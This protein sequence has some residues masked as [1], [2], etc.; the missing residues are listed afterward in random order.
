VVGGGAVTMAQLRI[1]APR[2]RRAIVTAPPPTTN[3]DL[4]VGH[5]SG[6][7]L[8]ADFHA[9]Y[10]R[11]RGIAARYQTGLDNH[12]SYVGLKAWQKGMAAADLMRAYNDAIVSTLSAANVDAAAIQATMDGAEHAALTQRLFSVLHEQG[13]IIARDVPSAHCDRCGMYLFEA[14]VRGKCA[15]CRADSCGGSCEVCG[16]PNDG[17]DLLE[18]RCNRC[19]G[20]AV[21]RDVRRLFLVLEHYRDELRRVVDDTVMPPSVRA[22]G[23]RMLAQPLPEI[24]VSHLT[25]C[26]VPV[27]I[28]GFE[29]QRI[30]AW[31]ELPVVYLETAAVE[32]GPSWETMWSSPDVDNVQFFGF[33]NSYFHLFFCPVVYRAAG[34]HIR[35]PR[36]F[37]VNEFLLLDGS[38]FSTSRNHAIW[39]RELIGPY[40][41]DLVRFYTAW[42]R[43]EAEQTNFTMTGFVETCR[44][45]LIDGVQRWLRELQARVAGEFGG[46]VPATG[47]WTAAHRAFYYDIRRLTAEAAS[48]WSAEHFSP[49]R[50]ARVAAELARLAGRFGRSEEAARGVER[51]WNERRTAVALECAAAKQLGLILHP[52]M[53]EFSASLLAALAL[54]PPFRWEDSPRWVAAGT[55]LPA[56]PWTFFRL[57]SLDGAVHPPQPLAVHG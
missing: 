6:P 8:A 17:G 41:A 46:A 25:D 31:F 4:H 24:A 32:G 54:S 26:G 9:R 15:H 11:M 47:L 7:Y 42:V 38:K 5:L 56:E 48:A 19:G 14:Y 44:R 37:V 10:L 50:A 43:P 45:E 18:A 22:L 40:G 51:L 39:G 29:G 52:L 12:P 13:G 3:G 1:R 33:D 20:P 34:P 53:P 16:W 55:R 49:S 23:E 21:I 28:A 2:A 27:P 30:Y 35:M 36:A 57:P